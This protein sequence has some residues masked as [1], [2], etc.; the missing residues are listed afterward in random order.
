MY[1]E[2]LGNIDV[3][4]DLFRVLLLLVRLLSIP[5]GREKALDLL[6]HALP[7]ELAVRRPKRDIVHF[8][9]NI[10][11]AFFFPLCSLRQS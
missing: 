8:R 5:A 11:L 10:G 2:V 1:G 7:R 9:G 6:F 3:A 4:L